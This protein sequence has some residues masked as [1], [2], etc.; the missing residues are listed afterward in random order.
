MHGLDTITKLLRLLL[1]IRD[2]EMAYSH[3]LSHLILIQ[4]IR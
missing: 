3:I 4:L 2:T 1:A